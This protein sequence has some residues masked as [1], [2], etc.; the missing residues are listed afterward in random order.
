MLVNPLR[1]WKATALIAVLF[2][3]VGASASAASDVEPPSGWLDVT[4]DRFGAAPGDDQP[5]AGAI[6]AAIDQAEALGGATVYLPRGVYQIDRALQIHAHGVRVTGD[7]IGTVLRNA[8]AEEAII[9]SLSGDRDVSTSLHGVIIE[10]LAIDGVDRSVTGI[11]ASGLTRGCVIRDVRITDCYDGV[12]LAGCWSLTLARVNVRGCERAGFLLAESGMR[13][14]AVIKRGSHHHAYGNGKTTPV[15]NALTMIGSTARSCEFGI[16]MGFGSGLYLAGN[17]F[18]RN[19]HNAF[20]RTP[21]SGAIMGNYFEASTGNAPLVRMGTTDGHGIARN[22]VLGGNMFYDGSEGVH[23]LALRGM[24]DSQ[25]LANRFDV[26][27]QAIHEPDNHHLAPQVRS[28]I[29]G[30]AYFRG[31]QRS[32]PESPDSPGVNGQIAWDGDYLYI[33]V[34]P[35]RW[36]RVELTERW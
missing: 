23:G 31:D 33:C 1:R 36:K 10:N 3:M 26:G 17:T 14:K 34:A 12:D 18:E 20:F 6:Q 27:G 29:Y 28:R 24:I 5:D 8:G 13:D 9:Q 19:E 15:V 21:Q 4:D 11:M 30:N 32:V 22:L 25:V 7:G 2:T 16:R 35:D